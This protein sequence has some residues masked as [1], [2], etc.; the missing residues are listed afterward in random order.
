MQNCSEEGGLH[1][2]DIAGTDLLQKHDA[3]PEGSSKSYSPDAPTQLP[4]SLQQKKT[5]CCRSGVRSDKIHHR[6]KQQGW[7]GDN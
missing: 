2:A 4:A 6:L 5:W 3:R 7:P 1:S